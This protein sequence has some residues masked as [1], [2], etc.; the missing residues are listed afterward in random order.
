MKQG[1]K[2]RIKLEGNQS[3]QFLK[4]IPELEKK[5]STQSEEIISKAA[6]YL[7]CFT[8]FGKVVQSSFGQERGATWEEDIDNFSQIYRS[9]N[10]SVTPK[11]NI[12]LNIYLNTFII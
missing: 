3:A 11:A 10:I 9:L 12:S 8:A 7:N 5:I 4:K 6:P 2:K 1:G